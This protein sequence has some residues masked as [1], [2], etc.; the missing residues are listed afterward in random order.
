MTE[1]IKDNS[2]C[3]IKAFENTNITIVK[4]NQNTIQRNR[5]WQS[6]RINKYTRT[7]QNYDEDEKVLRKA[8][9]HK[10]NL[11]D[12]TFLTSRGIYRLL[13]NSKK[14]IAKKFRKWVGNILDDII[15][16]QSKELT[17][18]LKEYEK[19]LEQKEQQLLLKDNEL[20]DK[21]QQKLSDTHDF[22]L[23]SFKKKSI[24]YLIFIAC[25]LYKFGNTDDLKRRL[26]EHQREIGKEIKLVFCIESKDNELLEQNLKDYLR[27]TNYRRNQIIN[28][29]NQTELIEIDD[30]SIIQNKLI[31]L[32]KKIEM[33]KE[34]LQLELKNKELELK[35]KDLE[36]KDKELEIQKAKNIY[37]QLQLSQLGGKIQEVQEK[38]E[39]EVQEEVQQVQE[40]EIQEQE[41]QE[42]QEQEV[43]EKQEEEVQEKQ[44][45]VVD[46]EELKKQKRKASINKYRS[47]DKYKQ[48]VKNYRASDK[49]KE[50]YKKLSQTEEFKQKLR[51][52]HKNYY[53]NNKEE[54]REKDKMKYTIM[55]TAN[56]DE[57]K[58]KFYEWLDNHIQFGKYSD[59]L[60]WG[61]FIEKYKTL[62]NKT[63]GVYRQHFEEYIKNKFNITEPYKQ[64][65][66]NKKYI[67]GWRFILA[68]D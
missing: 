68:I 3:I 30:I 14:P 48:V 49:Y 25:N 8:Y 52:Q 2:N 45:E 55:K 4:E 66:K 19:I 67:R 54:I 17:K 27:T 34:V 47:S 36:L 44:E 29:Q 26:S 28:E 10:G 9:D 62:N 59:V 31:E 11:Q 5:C 21:D 56:S 24:C 41:V 65:T 32:N 42:I 57:E 16:N 7:I 18:Q 43:Q 23:S 20:N 39:E 60:Q 6:I 40:Q 38:Q 35:N 37:L 13:Y 50:A 61:I 15:F 63:K 22:L 46:K 1:E 53:Q 58:S 64:I 33:N 51:E 12:I